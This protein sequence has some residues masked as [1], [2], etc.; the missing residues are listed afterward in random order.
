MS[1]RGNKLL[2]TELARLLTAAVDVLHDAV[3]GHAAHGR[4]LAFGVVVLDELDVIGVADAVVQVPELVR[5]RSK[6]AIC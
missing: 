2:N 3:H 6:V 5:Q 4:G 1:R